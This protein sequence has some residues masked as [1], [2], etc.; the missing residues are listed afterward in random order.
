[1]LLLGTL[2][3]L[4]LEL[5]TNP[6]DVDDILIEAGHNPDEVAARIRQITDEFFAQ[7]YGGA[8]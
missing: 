3:K 1:L 7:S 5:T 4:G 6:E 8:G 2:H